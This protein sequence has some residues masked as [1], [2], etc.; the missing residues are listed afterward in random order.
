M[1]ELLRSKIDGTILEYHE[2]DSWKVETIKCRDEHYSIVEELHQQYGNSGSIYVKPDK[3][4]LSFMIRKN[5]E[6]ECDEIY[7][8]TV[9]WLGSSS[10]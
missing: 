4:S 8:V 6:I 1:K 5:H 10:K 9:K 7:D 2:K 3:K